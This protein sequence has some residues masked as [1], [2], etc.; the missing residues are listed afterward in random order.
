MQNCIIVNL[1]DFEYYLYSCLN[2]VELQEG[3]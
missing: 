1:R 3:F 2:I